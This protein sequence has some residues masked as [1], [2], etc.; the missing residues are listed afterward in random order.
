MSHIKFYPKRKF[1]TLISI[2][3]L[4][5]SC[6]MMFLS[7]H[8]FGL[9]TAIASFL[10]FGIFIFFIF[11]VFKNQVVAVKDNCIVLYSFGKGCDL[12]RDDLLEIVNRGGGIFSYRFKKGTSHFQIS[13]HAYHNGEILENKLNDILFKQQRKLPNKTLKSDDYSSGHMN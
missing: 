11:P 10:S 5:V 7:F 2:I 4:L 8:T 12:S 1:V 3:S 9:K 13:P 6:A